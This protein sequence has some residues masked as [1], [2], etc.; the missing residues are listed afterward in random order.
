LSVNNLLPV[1]NTRLLKSYANADSRVV[2]ITRRVKTWAKEQGVHGAADGHLSSYAF[3][4]MVAFYMQI[5]GALPCLQKSASR[6]PAWYSEDSERY[7]VAMDMI[8]NGDVNPSDVNVSFLDFATFYTQEFTW[9]AHV[10]AVRTGKLAHIS[11]YK[12]LRAR[13]RNG[14]NEKENIEMLHIE[15]PLD[16][17]RNLNCV[18]AVGSSQKLFKALQ[19][20]SQS[21]TWYGIELSTMTYEIDVASHSE[22]NMSLAEALEYYSSHRSY[23]MQ[24]KVDALDVSPMKVHA[25]DDSPMKVLAGTNCWVYGSSDRSHE[26]QS[27]GDALYHCAQCGGTQDLTT[28]PAEVEVCYCVGCWGVWENAMGVHP[29]Y[30]ISGPLHRCALKLIATRKPLWYP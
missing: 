2:A 15:D 1:V 7:N 8:T 13:P 24:S 23:E 17:K 10:V 11:S 12:H 26:Y 27:N 20:A 9:G 3:T 6:N 28:D 22:K 18:L 21:R 5:R 16:T 19:C 30:R 14:I 4:L 29:N 25:L